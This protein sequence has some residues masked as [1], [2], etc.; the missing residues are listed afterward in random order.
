MY[1]FFRIFICAKIILRFKKLIE[2]CFLGDCEKNNG[3]IGCLFGEM[4]KIIYK[5][6]QNSLETQI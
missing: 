2:L 1:S 6:H 3:R 4:A 5:N